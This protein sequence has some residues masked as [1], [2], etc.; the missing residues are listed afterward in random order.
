MM[1]LTFGLFPQVSGSGPLGPLVFSQSIMAAVTV[2]Q[3]V[4]NCLFISV[5]NTVYTMAKIINKVRHG[6]MAA[7]TNA[8]VKML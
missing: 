3:N 7:A 6:M 4:K 8:L 1:S 2:I 5:Q